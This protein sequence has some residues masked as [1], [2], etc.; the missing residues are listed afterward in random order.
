MDNLLK[1]V[2][3]SLLHKLVRRLKGCNL[4]SGFCAS[5]IHPLDRQQVLKRLP[6]V[7][8]STERVDSEIFSESAP[9]VLKENCGVGVEK[10]QIQKRRGRRVTPD[11]KVTTLSDD[12]N[13]ENVPCSSRQKKNR[14]NLKKCNCK[15]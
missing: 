7:I 1:A 15:Q 12:K 8:T 4:V 11:E 2:F 10:K 13:D 9:Q 14:K 6:S 3:P 5:G